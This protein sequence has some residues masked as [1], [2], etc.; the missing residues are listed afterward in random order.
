[1][2]QPAVGND[3]AAGGN[4]VV[5]GYGAAVALIPSTGRSLASSSVCTTNKIVGQDFQRTL[6][7]VRGIT[8]RSRNIGANIGASVKAAFVGGEIDT[9]RNLCDTARNDAY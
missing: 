4:D 7:V 3:V 5:A 2:P 8:V 9:W 6:G 1:M